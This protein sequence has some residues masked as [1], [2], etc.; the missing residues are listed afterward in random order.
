MENLPR[1]GH[2]IK[3]TWDL[4]FAKPEPKPVEVVEEKPKEPAFKLVE[5]AATF[6]EH[7]QQRADQG[8]FRDDNPVYNKALG[9]LVWLEAEPK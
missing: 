4:P 7:M 3:D 5:P 2:E 6:A 9:T 1:E 8:T